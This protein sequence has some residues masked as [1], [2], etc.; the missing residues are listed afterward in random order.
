MIQMEVAIQV[1]IGPADQLLVGHPFLLGD[2]EDQAEGDATCLESVE[3]GH[4]GPGLNPVHPFV[5]QSPS[6][7]TPNPEHGAE[8]AT[9]TGKWGPETSL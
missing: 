5:Q 7:T 1:A 2:A 4:Q 3:M 8:G 9:V 6:H